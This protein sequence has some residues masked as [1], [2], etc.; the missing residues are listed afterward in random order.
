MKGLKAQTGRLYFYKDYPLAQGFS[1][2]ADALNFNLN[3]LFNPYASFS[4]DIIAFPLSISQN[5]NSYLGQALVQN[6]ANT[7]MGL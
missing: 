3:L 4:Q 1:F 6:N 5:T 7:I 2:K